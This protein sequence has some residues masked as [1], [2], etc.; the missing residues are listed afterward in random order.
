M[1]HEENATF[2]NRGAGPEQQE[3]LRLIVTLI[4]EQSCR[5]VIHSLERNGLMLVT[6]IP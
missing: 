6:L 4:G 5:R 3:L 1:A 2:L